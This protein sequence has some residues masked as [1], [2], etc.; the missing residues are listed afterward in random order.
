MLGAAHRLGLLRVLRHR[1]QPAPRSV[2]GLDFPNPV[3]L[4]AGYDKNGA[5]ID[6]LA[7]LGFGFI[8]VGTVTPR[9]QPG[10]AKPRLFRL[11]RA[12]A[13]INRM[14]FNNQGV[15]QMIQNIKRAKYRG[16]LGVSIGKNSDT[17]L[18]KAVDDYLYAL[19]QVYP[20]ASYIALNI[21]SP[22]TPK[23][24]QL[25]NKDKLSALLS[26]LKSRQQDLAARHNKYVPLVVKIAP[27]ISLPELEDIAELLI[28]Y[29]IDG[30]IAT[31][32]TL[33]RA[34]VAELPNGNEAGGLSGAPLTVMA[35]TILTQ[36]HAALGDRIPIIASGGIMAGEDARQRFANG[37]SLV[38][39]YSGLVYRGPGLI[40]E[41]LNAIAGRS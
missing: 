16:I 27:D 3:G 31:N 33:S 30:V 26:S 38:Q 25:Q 15:A 35:G 21:S 7:A 37:A 4:A 40:K 36:L 41:I 2:M 13:I 20:Y 22:G 11:P 39:V 32:T 12:R 18:D 17:P 9:P 8:E 5:Y 29:G 1:I 28:E 19:E 14:G 24:R 10:N 6:A 23:L 34:G